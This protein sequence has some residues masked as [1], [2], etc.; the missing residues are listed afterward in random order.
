MLALWALML[1]QQD[2]SAKMAAKA[3]R[4]VPVTPDLSAS[5]YDSPRTRDL[6][7]LARAARHEDD[8]RLRAY[9]ATA[10][11]RM[12]VD[13]NAARFVGTR[14][15]FRKET[16]ARVQ[17]ER[18]VGA[19][20]D[21]TGDRTA[22][23]MAPAA[24]AEVD[25]ETDLIPLPYVPGRPIPWQHA[26]HDTIDPDDWID[27][28]Q[29][30]AEAYYRYA[31]GDSQTVKAPGVEPV[32]LRELVLHPRGPEWNLGVGA[33]W[34]DIASGHL[35]RAVYRF[36]APMNIVAV[37]KSDDPHAFDDVPIWVRPFITPMVANVSAVIMEYGLLEARFWLPSSA[38]L[39]GTAQVGH[40]HFPFAMETRYRYTSINAADSLPPIARPSPD[41]LRDS[42]RRAECAAGTMWTHVDTAGSAGVPVL[43]RIP[44]DTAALAH[45]S[46]LPPSTFSAADVG[47]SSAQVN[48][49]LHA[50]GMGAQPDWAPQDIHLH[51]GLDHNLVRFNRIEGLSVGLGVSQEL[52]RGY[53]WYGEARFGVADRQP[54]AEL[55]LDESDGRSTIGLAVY[56][57]LASAN[58]WGDPFSLG[59]S[60]G[61][62][63]LGDDEGFYYRAWGAE[64]R[65]QS[66]AGAPLSWR[67]FAEGQ[68]TA[69]V[70]T[71]FSF[72]HALDG[73][74]A[75][76]NLVA[77]EGA[78]AGA[79]VRFAPSLGEDPHGF[80][81]ASDLR[82]EAAA[83]T[84]AYVRGAADITVSHGVT[85]FADASLTVG[86]GMSG[87]D[88][89]AQ[90]LWYLG[91]LQTVR[92]LAP[93]TEAGDAYWLTRAELGPRW[94][95]VKPVVFY[96][97]G[98][99]GDRN[100]WGHQG[101]ALSGAGAG[102]SF[103]DGL[104]RIN[105]AR[106]ISPTNGWRVNVY[107]NGAF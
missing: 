49:L 65:G 86:A 15:L 1:L 19:V 66:T 92:G 88:V 93:G 97:L 83:G 13:W 53:T 7:A 85:P 75:P 74:H 18:S 24:H 48:D 45:S 25:D 71:D 8:L 73:P 6:V 104:I 102:V 67:L 22:I 60:L 51:Y 46:T 29:P 106:G 40:L 17:W 21:V 11:Q 57:R 101:R 68:G 100:A 77:R 4:V 10:L 98:W 3:A 31:A 30:G 41:S 58:D 14:M 107:L 23:P 69:A 96:D 105:V 61:A 91:G 82:A 27:P 70:S 42:V 64:I 9:D 90:R 103:L 56:R 62:L 99:A 38:L 84:A 37:A 54:N 33:L 44:C 32:H 52:G 81:L 39:E 26:S 89:P 35:V 34:I 36:A 63:V 5:A 43:T 47:P 87:G 72:T 79:G 80:R 94:V 12:T 95:T 55:R 20:V 2:S 16:A 59:S 50:I 76:P 28:L 78:Y